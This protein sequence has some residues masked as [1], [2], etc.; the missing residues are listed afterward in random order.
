MD[1]RFSTSRLKREGGC[2]KGLG[3]SIHSFSRGSGEQSPTVLVFFAL[4]HIVERSL[5]DEPL[6]T[7]RR[8]LEG[9]G[10]EHPFLLARLEE[11]TGPDHLDRIF[12][13][14]RRSEEHTY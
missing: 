2:S 9:L 12:A 13:E 3:S 4:L 1:A 10:V 7:R 11:A 5:L 14:T 8:L 6:E